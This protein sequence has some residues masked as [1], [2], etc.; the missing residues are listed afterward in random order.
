MTPL[1]KYVL[2]FFFGFTLNT[3]LA[4]VFYGTRFNVHVG[5]NLYSFETNTSDRTEGRLTANDVNGKYCFNQ[6]PKIGLGIRGG[7][8]T[9]FMEYE[10]N[11]SYMTERFTVKYYEGYNGYN[12]YNSGYYSGVSNRLIQN[13]LLLIFTTNPT[14]KSVFNL[15]TGFVVDFA[16]SSEKTGFNSKMSYISSGPGDSFTYHNVAY[17]LGFGFGSPQIIFSFDFIPGLNYR[18]RVGEGNYY[19]VT[20]MVFNKVDEGAEKKR[21]MWSFTISY[22]FS[23]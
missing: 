17:L 13:Q 3:T 4:Q 20:S 21:K 11:L 14:K 1:K 16:I 9:R 22:Y 8:L 12:G 6:G 15:R 18:Y 23:L 10:V 5:Y 2:L 19:G 7:L